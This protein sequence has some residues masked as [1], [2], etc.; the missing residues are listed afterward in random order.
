MASPDAAQRSFWLRLRPH[1]PKTFLLFREGYSRAALTRDLIAGMTVGIIALPL[2]MAFAIASGLPPERGIF[3]AIVAGFVTSLLSGSRYV[4]GGPTGAFVVI[5][6]DIATRQG[7]DGLALA[8]LMAGGMLLLMGLFRFGAII[9]YIPYPV[10]TGFTSGIALVIFSSQIR[11][12]FGLRMESVPAEFFHKWDAYAAAARTWNPAAFGLAA[13]SLGVVILLR[14]FQ[15]RVPGAIVA[16]VLATL[17]AWAFRLPVETIGSRF[18]EI[19]RLLPAPTLP[20]FSMLRLRLLFPDALTIAMLAAIESLLCAVAADGMTG[21][22]HRS[23]TE[24]FGQG[25]ANVLSTLFGGIPTTGALARTATS[26]KSGAASPVAG[27]VHALTLLVVTLAAAPLATLIPLSAL[28]AILVV[29][30]WNMS[31]IDHFR[32]MFKAPRSDALVMLVTFGL[33]VAVDLTLAVQVGVVLAALLFMHRMSEVTQVGTAA[34]LDLENGEETEDDPDATRN[35]IVPP[36][37]EVYEINGPFFFGVADRLQDELSSFESPPQVFVLR[38]RRV[39]AI[40]A[41]GMQALKKFAEKC[42]R[43]GMWLVLSGVQAQ[44]RQAIAKAGLDE[45]IGPEN[46]HPHIDLAL[47]RAR[48]LVETIAFLD[49]HTSP[50]PER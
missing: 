29:V 14:R 21:D 23:N 25:V 44:P 46:I 17:A 33:T 30:A 3:T 35:K 18:G 49:K 11:D 39:P 43:D 19:P 41:T 16:V 24:L 50:G 1:L 36:G 28:A 31:E 27:M 13:G 4:I 22:R 40:D 26:I 6:F 20:E 9:K 2:A 32:H 10:V 15:P 8:T 38:M 47:A 42:R 48:D 5:V 37:V 7:Y 12:F 45:V 34:L